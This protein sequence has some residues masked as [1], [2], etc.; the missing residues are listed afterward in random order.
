[1]IGPHSWWDVPWCIGGDFNTT[2]FPVER[3]GNCSL[4]P[5]MLDFFEFILD[6]SLM[7]IPIS[8]CDFYLI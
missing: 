4:L 5:C 7:D 3:F 8:S 6:L 1:M 2:R